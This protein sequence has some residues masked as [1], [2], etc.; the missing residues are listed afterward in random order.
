VIVEHDTV[1]ETTEY[2]NLRNGQ[3]HQ[4]AMGVESDGPLLPTHDLSGGRGKDS[5]KFHTSP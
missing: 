5:T 3:I 2:I 4:Y 1:P